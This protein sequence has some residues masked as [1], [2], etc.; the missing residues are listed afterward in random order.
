[1]VI[2]EVDRQGPKSEPPDVDPIVARP[3]L[4]QL[5]PP[6]KILCAVKVVDLYAGATRPGSSVGRAAHS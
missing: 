3:A 2:A 1:V 5:W 4:T 6:S